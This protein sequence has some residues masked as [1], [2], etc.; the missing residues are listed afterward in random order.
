MNL[1]FQEALNFGETCLF[2]LT[3][4]ESH[5]WGILHRGS[6]LDPIPKVQRGAAGYLVVVSAPFRGTP[7]NP[8]EPPCEAR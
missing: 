4:M 6:P 5:L 7:L 2:A 8:G 1:T 3:V